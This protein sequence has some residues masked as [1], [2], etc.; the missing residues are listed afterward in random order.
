MSTPSNWFAPTTITQ[1]FTD[2]PPYIPWQG[3]TGNLEFPL[4]TSKD[5]IHIANSGGPGPA[6]TDIRQK[7]TCLYLTGFNLLD[8]PETVNGIQLTLDIQRNGRIADAEVFLCHN[9]N[10]IGASQVNYS[11]DLEDHLLY[12]NVNDYGGDGNNW[13]VTLTT[14]LL[15]DPTF[16]VSLRFQSHP[17]YPHRCGCRLYGIAL[18]YFYA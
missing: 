15:Q 4:T 17:F 1:D 2:S 5:L 3:I 7:T 8:V 10:Q 16:G 12:F 6:M 9:G 13:G 11:A 14:D 18:R